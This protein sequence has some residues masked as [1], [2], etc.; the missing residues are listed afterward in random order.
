[1]ASTGL[2]GFVDWVGVLANE[3]IEEDKMSMLAAK[4]VAWMR[5]WDV[6]LE[7]EPTSHLMGSVLSGLRQT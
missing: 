4:F 1:M 7:D 6:D 3:S 2:E 5:K